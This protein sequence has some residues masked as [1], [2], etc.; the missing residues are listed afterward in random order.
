LRHENT[1]AVSNLFIEQPWVL[2]Y[3]KATIRSAQ[4]L[5][6]D[7]YANN[8]VFNVHFDYFAHCSNRSL[9]NTSLQRKLPK[10]MLSIRLI[11]AIGV[12]FVN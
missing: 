12:C 1:S 8:T 7:L 4:A 2:S 11:P 5:E 10:F 3:E 9:Q 6:K